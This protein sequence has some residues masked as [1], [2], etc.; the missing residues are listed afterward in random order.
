[1]HYKLHMHFK[2]GQ[3]CIINYTYYFELL[4]ENEYEKEKYTYSHFH[5]IQANPEDKRT[6]KF[7]IQDSIYIAW[8]Q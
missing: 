2:K 8:L 1:M 3:N 6:Q 5:T 4:W 7:K